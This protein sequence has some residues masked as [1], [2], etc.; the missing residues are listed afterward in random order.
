MATNGACIVGCIIVF[1]GMN[2]FCFSCAPSGTQ[3][4]IPDLSYCPRSSAEEQEEDK[5]E[6]AVN[7]PRGDEP[8]RGADFDDNPPG[9]NAGVALNS[10]AL[11]LKNIYYH[12]H[13]KGG[14]PAIPGDSSGLAKAA[15]S[16]HEEL[17]P[18]PPLSMQR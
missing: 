17:L 7:T 1:A 16:L 11:M 5:E 8:D 2:C 10:V 4:F 15:N 6:E 12:Y 18:P 14:Q 9:P 13:P 3:V